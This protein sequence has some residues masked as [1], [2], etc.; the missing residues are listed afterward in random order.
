MKN[1]IGTIQE[2]KVLQDTEKYRLSL[3]K[4]DC[5]DVTT[6][7][8][9]ISEHFKIGDKV[10][11]DYEIVEK[12][13]KVFKTIKTIKIYVE[14]SKEICEKISNSL[15]Q[16]TEEKVSNMIENNIFTSDFEL[17]GKVYEVTI[18]RKIYKG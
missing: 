17:D 18:N 16:P 13:D 3:V 8:K 10:E 9:D 2:I 15:N 12:D 11:I 14:G 6:F 4:L 5:L 1:I 7:D